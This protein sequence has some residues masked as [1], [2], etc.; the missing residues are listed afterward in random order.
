MNARRKIPIS[1]NLY[2]GQRLT[3][4]LDLLELAKDGQTVV[5]WRG[6]NSY[7]IQPACVIVSMQ[8]RKVAIWVAK[9]MIYFTHQ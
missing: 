1:R 7:S 5:V 8:F 4:P 2:R 6:N 9:G 3:N